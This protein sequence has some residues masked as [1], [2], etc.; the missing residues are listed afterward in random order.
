MDNKFN[1][2]SYLIGNEND[3][4]E[5][6]YA[7]L[8]YKPFREIVIKLFTKG[9]FGA[10]DI[11]WDDIETQSRIGNIIPDMVFRNDKV[12]VL[13]EVKTNCYCGLTNNQPGSYL[14]WLAGPEPKGSRFFVALIPSVYN[15]QEK[16][17]KRIKCFQ[18]SN[19]NNSVTDVI[20]TWNKLIQAVAENDLR[21]LNQYIRDFCS[22]LKSWYE[23][24]T[25]K[26]I[27]E[28]TRLMYDR[29]N[30]IS[31]RKILQT[32]EDVTS[33]LKQN[34]HE[35]EN[36]FNRLWWKSGEYGCYI[37]FKGNYLLFFGLWQD[38][39][40]KSGQP[41]CYGIDEEWDSSVCKAFRKDHPVHEKHEAYLIKNITQLTLLSEDPVSSIIGILEK[42]VNNLCN[43][44]KIG[45][46]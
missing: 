26:F 7:L 42:E 21:E 40:E 17:E 16:L 15:H 38:Y 20:I 13:V 43:Q 4:T 1:V 27:S 6:F 46:C 9:K 2:L 35:I 25:I 44:V 30:A 24:P 12:S 28:E 33:T 22:L 3:T 8:V 32:V 5:M 37:K 45:R 36:S 34:G 41:L 31:I 14:G 29:N 23:V 18:K 10:D 11:S 19:E 39:W